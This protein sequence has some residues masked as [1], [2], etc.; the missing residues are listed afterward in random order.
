MWDASCFVECFCDA[1]NI[2][3]KV[4][5]ING[6][7]FPVKPIFRSYVDAARKMNRI[8]SLEINKV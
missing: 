6:R 8:H 3:A 7:S 1:E 4:N 2:F 5:P